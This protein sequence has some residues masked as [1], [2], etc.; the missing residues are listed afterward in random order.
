VTGLVFAALCTGAAALALPSP[1]SMA[2]AVAVPHRL[3]TGRRQ[4][5]RAPAAAGQTTAARTGADVIETVAGGVGGPVT[6]VRAALSYPCG[7]SYRDGR[8]YI[9]DQSA[10]RALSPRTDWLTTPAGTGAAHGRLGNG[11]P[12]A[13]TPLDGA[14]WATADSDGNLVITDSGHNRIRVVAART[15]VFYGQPMTAGDIYTIAG[16]GRRGF[17]GD[18]GPAT[19]AAL[20]GPGAVAID[21]GGNLVIAALLNNRI[22]VV[23]ARTGVFYGR[24][25]T[26]GD[27]YTVAGDGPPGFAGDGGPALAARLYNPADVAVDPAGNLVIAD[28]QND[29]IRVVAARTGVFYGRPMVTG[30]IYTVAGDGNPGLAGDGGPALDAE[31]NAPEGVTLDPAGNLVIADAGNCRIRVVAEHTGTY[32]GRPM[33]AHDIYTVAGDTSGF[34]CAGYSGDGGPAVKAALSGP[35]GVAVDGAGNLLIADSDNQRLR[36]VAERTGTFYG[37]AMTA[38]DIYTVAGGGIA[39]YAGNGLPA[40]RAQLDL[41][42]P[43]GA[44][45]DRA[46]NLL[47][48]DPLLNLVRVV[49]H[50]TGTFY[51]QHMTAGSIYTVAGDGPA[52]SGNGP[53]TH[54]RLSE[55]K[56]VAVDHTGN[57]LIADT[58]DNRIRVVAASTGMFYGQPMTAGSIYTVAG[59][60]H[61]G[62]GGDGALATR[63]RV[64]GP[65][66]VAVDPRGNLVIDDTENNRIRVVADSSGT[67]YGQHMSAGDI[68][69]V[70]GDGAQG[71]SG[72]GGPATRAGLDPSAVAVDSRGNLIIADTLNSRIRVVADSSGT[73]YG[74]HM[75]AGDIYTVAGDGQAGY[76]GDGGRATRAELSLPMGVAVD[77][78]GNLLAADTLNDRVRVVAAHT[79]TFYGQ[80]MTAGDIYTIA[81]NGLDG[82]A[83]DGGPATRAELS[84][85]AAVAAAPGGRV[86]IVDARN[87]RIRM[88]HPPPDTGK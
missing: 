53:A 81:G 41:L 77:T 42:Y 27:I 59:D 69:T 3:F 52:A 1:V 43:Q 13:A 58:G 37:L 78:A 55:P 79:G 63:A 66:A 48:A 20:G 45:V 38:G 32:Y 36:V 16:N 71:Y 64:N 25:M 8:V 67:F 72:D 33:T 60:G 75:S 70:A 39:E 47:I 50:S 9:A 4:D 22:R 19:A 44:A 86:Y 49:A 87:E 14:C 84:L 24:P 76:R 2:G 10:V 83:G 31:M 23:A 12:A 56:G 34:I 6:G 85:P 40:T 21:P 35:Y 18:G 51:G 54:T 88:I 5:R 29:R 82:F 28:T 62:F 11:L 57:L 80:P 61:A 30:D 17:G 68:Y 7:V 46:G 15:G 26:A 74:Q 65:D 73:F